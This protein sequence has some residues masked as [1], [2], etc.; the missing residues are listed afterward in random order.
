MGSGML[1]VGAYVTLEHEFILIF[2]KGNKKSFDTREKKKRRSESAFFWEERNSWFS[3][4][5]D[6][7][8]AKQKLRESGRSRSGAYP[9]EVPY[10]LINMFSLIGDTVLDPFN[11]TATTT[12]AAIESGRNSIGFEIDH[13][14]IE[15]IKR[16]LLT[17][18][19][20]ELQKRQV[21]RME[22]HRSFIEAKGDSYFKYFNHH[23][24]F[25]VK[26]RQEIELVLLLAREIEE[27][28]GNL[29]VTYK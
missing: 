26:T 27:Q 18:T 2:R 9:L 24:D 5:W 21:M 22:A 4:T 13:S 12:R 14:L 3:D 29:V 11:G 6:L 28:S 10:R 17:T 7:I 15:P 20:D 25:K 1:P 8:G 23:H 16:K 19:T